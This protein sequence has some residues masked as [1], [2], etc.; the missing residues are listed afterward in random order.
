MQPFDGVFDRGQ[1]AHNPWPNDPRWNINA[2]RQGSIP[3]STTSGAMV[4]Q[5]TMPGDPPPPPAPTYWD[6]VAEAAQYGFVR[7]GDTFI[8][9]SYVNL[10]I[11]LI[12]VL[13]SYKYH[14]KSRVY[15]IY[16]Y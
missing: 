2:A 5:V 13:D 3:A 1:T 7:S 9:S 4:A 12:I 15:L 14:I 16:C 11:F 6:V 10:Y 8:H